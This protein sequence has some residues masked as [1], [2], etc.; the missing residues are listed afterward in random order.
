MSIIPRLA[1]AA[2]LAALAMAVTLPTV[3]AQPSG[4]PVRSNACFRVSELDSLKAGG[5]RIVY[6]R[7]SGRVYRIDLKNECVGLGDGSDSPILSPVS[8]LVCAPLDL[9]ITMRATH[10]RCVADAITRL[11]SDE[12]AALPKSQ[13]P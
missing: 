6:A 3:Q 12:V 8:D 4:G 1:A 7:V 9:N 10:E 5:P 2:G 13:R 11:S